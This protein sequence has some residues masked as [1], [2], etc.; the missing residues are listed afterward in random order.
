MLE[1]M[2]SRPHENILQ[3]AIEIRILLGILLVL[4]LA[5][6]EIGPSYI[7]TWCH[8]TRIHDIRSLTED[9]KLV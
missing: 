5:Q 1:C 4:A 6:E 8:F 7:T 3:L 9:S 2:N